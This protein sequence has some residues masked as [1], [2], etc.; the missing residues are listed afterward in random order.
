MTRTERE[1]LAVALYESEARS[2]GPPAWPAWDRTTPYRRSDFRR[3]AAR[4]ERAA[5]EVT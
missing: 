1:L 5:G 3:R 2:V 4:L